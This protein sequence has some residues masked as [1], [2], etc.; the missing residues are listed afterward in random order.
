MPGMPGMPGDPMAAGADPAAALATSPLDPNTM[1]GSLAAEGVP[2]G[3]QMPPQTEMAQAAP[4]METAAIQ[5]QQTMSAE[6]FTNIE[7]KE[8][9]ISLQRWTSILGRALERTIE[10]QQRVT[11]EKISGK[12]AKK[13]LANGNLSIDTIFNVDVWNRQFDEDI[14]PVLSTIVSDSLEY[15]QKTLEKI[16]IIAN[17]D[18]QMQR[19]KDINESTYSTLTSAYVS[20]LGVKDEEHRNVVFK[21]NCVAIFSNLLAK[22]VADFCSN[23]S[24]RAWMFGS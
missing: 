6:P 17:I 18:A 19:F 23:E 24:R 5:P 15:S 13:S 8:D 21:S 22:T 12:Q 16:D 3:G 10:R 4:P 2:P 7:T 1:A 9:N 20:S 14:R 11:L